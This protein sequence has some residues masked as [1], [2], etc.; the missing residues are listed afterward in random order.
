MLGVLVWRVT[1]P[2][3]DQPAEVMN[4]PA[5]AADAPGG[6]AARSARVDSA[7]ET[8]ALA[9]S[10]IGA[11]GAA[12]WATPDTLFR[13]RPAPADAAEIEARAAL[14]AEWVQY[15]DVNFGVFGAKDS[16]L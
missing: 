10:A 15:V 4:R 9:G 1:V 16:P 6:I 3:A 14:P 5:S 2:P 11:R 12:G 13:N 7:A 8:P